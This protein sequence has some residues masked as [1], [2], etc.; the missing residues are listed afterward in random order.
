MGLRVN[1]NIPAI[2]ALRHLNQSDA[3]QRRSL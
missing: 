1:T 2:N 3:A